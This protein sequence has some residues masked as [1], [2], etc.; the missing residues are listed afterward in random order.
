[1]LGNLFS[2][3]SYQSYHSAAIHQVHGNSD[4]FYLLAVDNNAST[5]VECTPTMGS[6]VNLKL[7]HV[8][9]IVRVAI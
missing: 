5:A 1:M 9:A 6:I 3:N 4:Q 2:Y 8:S 7:P